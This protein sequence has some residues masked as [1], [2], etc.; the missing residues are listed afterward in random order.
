[1]HKMIY[2]CP[3]CGG[4]TPESLRDTLFAEISDEEEGRLA[5]LTQGI[6]T[7]EDAIVKFGPPEYDDPNGVK[8]ETP[9]SETTGPVIQ[10]FRKITYTRLSGTADVHI[11]D[12]IRD[13]VHIAFQGKYIG[14]SKEN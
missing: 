7:L 9:E 4:R 12:F 5:E 14:S 2:H 6:K 8:I 10:S 11:T 1:G 13:R 3:F